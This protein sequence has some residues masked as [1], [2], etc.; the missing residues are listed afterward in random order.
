M[1]TGIEVN[2]KD[3]NR[4]LPEGTLMHENGITWVVIGKAVENGITHYSRVRQGSMAH[5]LHQQAKP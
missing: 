5:R 3:G 2:E 1:K 4:N